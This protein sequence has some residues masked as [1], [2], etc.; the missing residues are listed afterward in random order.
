MNVDVV[1]LLL[2]IPNTIPI[3][4][5]LTTEL[6]PIWRAVAATIPLASV[7][8]S[9]MRRNALV[10][11]NTDWASTPCTIPAHRV[12]TTSRKRKS[13]YGSMPS[14]TLNRT[15]NIDSGSSSSHDATLW[16]V[17][18]KI[19]EIF[20]TISIRIVWRRWRWR[21]VFAIAIVISMIPR[22]IG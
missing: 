1:S 16:R 12:V 7:V 3:P 18:L 15:L 10:I 17:H 14:C 5:H 22:V 11:I 21:V 20:W 13:A 19:V 8:D 2:P 6:C 4:I 9:N